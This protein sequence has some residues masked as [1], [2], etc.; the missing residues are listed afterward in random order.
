M[1]KLKLKLK[2]IMKK[3]IIIIDYGLGNLA[4]VANALKKLEIPYEISGSIDVIKNSEAL[5]L[6][7]V[8]A[9]GQGMKN[10][11]KRKLDKVIVEQIQKGIPFFGICLGMQLLLSESEEGNVMCLGVIQGK[12]KKLQTNLK[13]PEIGW[14][15][16]R[17]MNYESRIMKDISND[18]YFYFINSYVCIPEDKKII[19][20]T[21]NYGGDFCSVF[22]KENIFGVQFHPEKSG[23][24]GLMLLKNFWEVICK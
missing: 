11:K 17:I 22:E 13:I 20:G 2:L 24:A 14:N 3:K 18:N 5:I 4:S 23:E 8:G 9:A 21:T 7:G 15:N 19:T 6:P 1:K 12:A 16:V 10:L